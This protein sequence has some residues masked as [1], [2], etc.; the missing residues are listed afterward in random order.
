M[1]ARRPRGGVPSTSMS[2]AS[3]CDLCGAL[4][5]R[6]P[7]A[8]T[9]I[10]ICVAT[11]VK[12]GDDSWQEIDFCSECRLIVPRMKMRPLAITNCRKEELQIMAFSGK[13]CS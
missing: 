3:E 8:V 11:G 6:V 2:G 13:R 12:D 9:L 1:R 10:N 7:G 4:F 5:K